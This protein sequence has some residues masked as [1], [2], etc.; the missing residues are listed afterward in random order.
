VIVLDTS[1]ALEALLADGEVAVALRERLADDGELLAPHLIDTELLHVLRRLAV[2][3][4]I[5]QDRASDVRALFARLALVRCPHEPLSDRVWELRHN[6]SA[7]DATF[8]ALAEILE[9]PL[10]TCDA[11]VASAPGHRAR[12]ELFRLAS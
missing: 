8:V 12:V 6:L 2:L 5:S 10:V 9:A 7:Y 11:R 1:A 3:G 4:V